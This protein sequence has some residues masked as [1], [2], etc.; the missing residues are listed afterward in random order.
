MNRSVRHAHDEDLPVG[1]EGCRV[2]VG[3]FPKRLAER[4]GAAEISEI[5]QANGVVVTATNH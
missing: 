2:D 1:T 5:P 4:H 3:E